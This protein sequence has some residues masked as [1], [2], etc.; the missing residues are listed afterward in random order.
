MSMFLK[1]LFASVTEEGGFEVHVL[2]PPLCPIESD[3]WVWSPGL[4]IAQTRL[5]MFL[6]G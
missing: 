3:S 4:C 2:G 6:S 5:V 1:E